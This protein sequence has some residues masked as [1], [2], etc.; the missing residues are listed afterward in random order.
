MTLPAGSLISALRMTPGTVSIASGA[1]PRIARNPTCC[2]QVVDEQR[3]DRAAP[4][5]SSRRRSRRPSLVERRS[6]AP[7]GHAVP[8]GIVTVVPRAPRAASDASAAASVVPDVVQRGPPPVRST[9]VRS[10][11]GPG[12]PRRTRR[13]H[14]RTMAIRVHPLERRPLFSRWSPAKVIGGGACSALRRPAFASPARS[15]RSPRRTAPPWSNGP[16][17]RA[18]VRRSC[19]DLLVEHVDLDLDPSRHA[20]RPRR[21]LR[22]DRGDHDQGQRHRRTAAVRLRAGLRRPPVGA[23]V[24][25]RSLAL[26]GRRRASRRC[27]RRS[28]RRAQHQESPTAPEHANVFVRGWTRISGGCARTATRGRG[29]TT[30]RRRR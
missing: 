18:R 9:S 24:G 28:D 15:R 8:L 26:V 17:L 16:S 2:S 3:N 23:V 4:R 11:P 10:Q 29:R 19:L 12:R 14:G 25:R 6:D 1:M 21:R 22:R 27:R 13:S 5:L 30:A 20:A 7:D